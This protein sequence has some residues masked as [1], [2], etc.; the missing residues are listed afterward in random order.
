MYI[1]NNTTCRRFNN[2]IYCNLRHDDLVYGSEYISHIPLTN[3]QYNNWFVQY[4]VLYQIIHH[5]D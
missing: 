4:L 5:C 1:R 2:N 3:Y